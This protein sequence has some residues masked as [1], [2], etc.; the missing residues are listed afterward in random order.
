MV[1]SIKRVLDYQIITEERAVLK[2]P[3]EN[4]GAHNGNNSGLSAW[5]NNNLPPLMLILNIQVTKFHRR[6]VCIK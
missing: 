4:R 5:S 6:T 3:S 1:A 2:G